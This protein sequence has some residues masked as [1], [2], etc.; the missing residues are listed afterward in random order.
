[1]KNLHRR[2]SGFP[3]H[4]LVGPPDRWVRRASAASANFGVFRPERCPSTA[5]AYRCYDAHRTK[6]LI[7]SLD[8]VMS[9]PSKAEAHAAQSNSLYHM[10]YPKC[11]VV[12]SF[13]FSSSGAGC[14]ATGPIHSVL[15]G[16][17][18]GTDQSSLQSGPDRCDGRRRLDDGSTG[19]WGWNPFDQTS[20]GIGREFLE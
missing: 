6:I 19:E 8:K 5:E 18:P 9:S 16:F 17:R 3:E 15:R 10:L 13:Q 12:C 4:Q 1:M 7:A 20:N 14:P 11:I 2:A